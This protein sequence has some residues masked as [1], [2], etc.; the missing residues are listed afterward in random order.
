LAQ[1][2]FCSTCQ[3]RIG[4]D[5]ILPPV[6][7]PAD[8][9]GWDQLPMIVPAR[10]TYLL[11]FVGELSRVKSRDDKK[12]VERRT[13]DGFSRLSDGE[14]DVLNRRKRRRSE[15]FDDGTNISSHQESQTVNDVIVAT[16]KLAQTL[17]TSDVFHFQFTC[18]GANGP[19]TPI[20]QTLTWAS[21]WALCATESFRAAILGKSTFC[22]ILVPSNA[23][24]G[25]FQ[26]SSTLTQTRIYEALK[27]GAIPVVLGNVALPFEDLID[28]T[29][30]QYT[31]FSL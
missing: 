25:V 10:R 6:L 13:V 31:L 29:S 8:G 12:I 28:Y 14:S 27:A 30:M 7:G 26:T 23:G 20:E 4:F 22:L 9:D 18:D 19:P 21:E 2:S 16:L 1:S 17:S 3:P 15:T 24:G 11:S 5:V